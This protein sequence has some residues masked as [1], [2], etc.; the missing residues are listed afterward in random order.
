MTTS[1]GV[2]KQNSLLKVIRAR[3]YVSTFELSTTLG[4]KDGSGLRSTL[5]EMRDKGLVYIAGYARGRGAGSYTP[6]YAAGEAP[7]A[8][9]PGIGV[10]YT[11]VGYLDCVARSEGMIAA[12]Q[13]QAHVH[14]MLRGVVRRT[15]FVGGKNP[16]L[17]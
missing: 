9:P 17:Q 16:W 14:G 2:A 11:S 12:L 10:N 6:Y 5:K 8:E 7:G 13:R 3:G 1:F 4:L 15:E